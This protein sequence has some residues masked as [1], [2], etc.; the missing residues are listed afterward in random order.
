[1]KF[2]ISLFLASIFLFSCKKDEKEEPETVV[3]VVQT[4]APTP[5]T[6]AVS[7][8]TLFC[9]KGGGVIKCQECNSDDI[10]QIKMEYRDAG[11]TGVSQVTITSCDKCK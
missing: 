9:F 11:I 1:M 4:P 6:P 7:T 2:I 3:V 10:V 8:K 5:T